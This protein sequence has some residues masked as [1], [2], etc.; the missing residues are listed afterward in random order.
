MKK[1]ILYFSEISVDYQRSTWHYSPEDKALHTA[2]RT[3][4]HIH[5]IVSYLDNSVG[6]HAKLLG[7][8]A[9]VKPAYNNHYGLKDIV[10]LHNYKKMYYA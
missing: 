5:I 3:S 10:V 9:D 4:E 1:E 2:V 8:K 6:K 7:V